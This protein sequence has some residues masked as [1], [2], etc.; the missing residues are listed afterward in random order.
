MK[1]FEVLPTDIV[2]CCIQKYE[3]EYIEEWLK[4]NFEKVGFDKIIIFDDDENH[5][6]QNNKYIIDNI[7][8]GK[9]KI[10]DCSNVNAPQM[11]VYN[12]F[13][14]NFKPYWVAFLDC[15]EF[16][17][18]KSYKSIKDYIKF[19]EKKHNDCISIILP[20]L[21]YGDNEQLHKTNGLVQDRFTKPFI[22]E[23][24]INGK[25]IEKGGLSGV[26]IINPHFVC[27]D[28]FYGV[29]CS[30]DGEIKEKT[31]NI[32][33]DAFCERNY[34]YPFIKHY[35]TKSTEEFKKK[36][37]RGNPD[38]TG[39]RKIDEYFDINKRTKEKEKIL[40]ENN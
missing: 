21:M 19:I 23:G 37:D 36:L 13:Y 2:L 26:S 29:H 16:I 15:D 12:W 40:N 6:I 11:K 38:G 25:T 28:R 27:D 34:D 33:D 10:F 7:K 14:Y 8:N 18:L 24:K 17:D 39:K 3:D 5:T 4:W 1:N 22:E 30:N 31:E 20:W 9:I 35:W 32:S